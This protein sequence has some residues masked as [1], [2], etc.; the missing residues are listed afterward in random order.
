MESL[1]FSTVIKAVIF[2]ALKYT[3]L[4]QELEV[5]ISTDGKRGYLG[6]GATKMY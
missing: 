6:R 3:G 5:G 1:R 4:L 2:R